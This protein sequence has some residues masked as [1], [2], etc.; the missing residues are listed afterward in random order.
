MQLILDDLQRIDLDSLKFSRTLYNKHAITGKANSG[1]QF[2]AYL[3][4][5]N[6]QFDDFGNSIFAREL[7]ESAIFSVTPVYT[8][9]A[10]IDLKYWLSQQSYIPDYSDLEPDVSEIAYDISDLLYGRLF[11]ECVVN[12]F[13]LIKYEVDQKTNDIIDDHERVSLYDISHLSS[14]NADFEDVMRQFVIVS[15]IKDRLREFVK[16]NPFNQ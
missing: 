7:M 1:D 4:G 14:H 11:V 9:Q 2:N 6:Y 5:E 12:N 15:Y 10:D 13:T 8:I 16:S 3:D